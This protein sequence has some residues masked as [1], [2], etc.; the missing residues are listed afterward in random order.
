MADADT[1][2]DIHDLTD[3]FV[4]VWNEPDGERRRAAIRELWSADAV[5]VLRP[6]QD[7]LETARGL[8]FDQ[9]LLEARGH[10]AWELRV[11]RAQE[12]FVAPGTYVFRSRGNTDRLR[13]VVRFTWEMAPRDGGEV[14]GV[15]LEILMLGPDGRIVTDYQF[16]EG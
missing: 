5:H 4:A 2:L 12:E 14:A 8:G 3:R 6:P 10:H 15:G 13:D 9:P 1:V 16:I 11:T 7:I